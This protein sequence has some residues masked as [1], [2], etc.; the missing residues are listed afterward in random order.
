M[1]TA[2]VVAIAVGC[3]VVARLRSGLSWRDLLLLRGCFVYCRLLHRWSA[4]RRNPFPLHGPAI[5]VCN[6][7]CSAD[8]TFILAACDRPIGFLVAAEHFNIHPVAH[9]ILEYLHCVPVVRTGNDPLALRRALTRLA[10]GDLVCLFPEGNLSGVSRNR[11]RAAKPGAAFL[12]LATRLPV[13]PAH[14]AGGPRTDDLLKSWVLPSRRA[15]RVTYGKPVDL[16]AYY[17]RPRTRQLI[18]E[19]TCVLMAKIMELGRRSIS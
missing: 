15:V 6:H 17:H 10:K 9:A 13:Y 4:N 2:A 8:A 11:C 18:D 3:L 1:W 12:A 19:V 16:T 7:T 14:I 5:I